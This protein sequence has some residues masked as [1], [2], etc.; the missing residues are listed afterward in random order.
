[1]S[2]D[3]QNIIDQI[4]AGNVDLTEL[5][6]LSSDSLSSN[7]SVSDWE[8]CY[9]SATGQLSEYCTVTANNSN[10]PI[11]GVGL[12]AYTGNGATMLCLQYSNGFSTDS[13]ATSIG[14]TLYTPSMGNSALCIVYGWTT[15]GSF[16]FPSTMTIGSC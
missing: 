6:K 15:S 12:I 11:T 7:V 2:K 8:I 10:D 1:M 14:T 16:Y 5:E 3:E 4:K 9:S 13:I